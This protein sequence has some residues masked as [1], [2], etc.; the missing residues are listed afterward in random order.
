MSM[1]EAFDVFFG[2]VRAAIGDDDDF[3][4]LEMFFQVVIQYPDVRLYHFGFLVAGDDD[5]YFR[6]FHTGSLTELGLIV[7]LHYS[8]KKRYP[9]KQTILPVLGRC[10]T[11]QAL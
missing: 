4:T 11:I 10:G 6:I 7:L 2:S 8:R 9:Q 1:T 3:E 5:G